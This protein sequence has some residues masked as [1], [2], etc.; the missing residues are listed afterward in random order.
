MTRP[1]S[2][3]CPLAHVS[4]PASR[5][6]NRRSLLQ[7]TLAAA[8]ATLLALPA[9]SQQI[10]PIRM[11]SRDRLLRDSAVARKLFAAEQRMTDLLQAQV[12]EAKLALATEEAEL[13]ELRSQLPKD[14]FDQR[15]KDF[16]ARMRRARLITQERSALL[17]KG[18][19]DARAQVVAAIPAILEQL[20]KET[21]ATVILNAD[22]VMAATPE[23]DLT[24]RAVA[25]LDLHGPEGTIP[26]I[27]LT[28]P[29]LELVTPADQGDASQGGAPPQQ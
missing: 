9:I 3:A 17:Q 13:A 28:L 1:S 15:I 25:L 27:D 18:F 23:L 4:D 8:S 5:R 16:D 19:Q 10:R 7:A 24:D 14:A 21:G 22:Q 29:V 6:M 2:S 11:V 26:Q 12:D 20:R